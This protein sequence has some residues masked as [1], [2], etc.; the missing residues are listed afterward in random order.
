[1][2]PWYD[3]YLGHLELIAGNRGGRRPDTGALA[4]LRSAA[5][6]VAFETRALRH[7]VPY[8][9]ADGPPREWE[10]QVALLVGHLYATYP[11]E[12]GSGE[13]RRSV[14]RL[15]GLADRESLSKAGGVPDNAQPTPLERHLHVLVATS[16]EQLSSK[17][18]GSFT[19][20]VRQHIIPTT[21]DYAKLLDD[22]GYWRLSERKVQYRWVHDFYTTRTVGSKTQGGERNE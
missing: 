17:L 1:M 16:F 9:S 21:G 11:P 6:G 20:V 4:E 3:G 10:T 13:A 8:L 2:T 14:G 12:S 19:R 18:R 22:L 7:V 5:R 15:L